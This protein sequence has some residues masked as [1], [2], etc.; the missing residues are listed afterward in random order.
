MTIDEQLTSPVF[1]AEADYYALF[2][3]LRRE[4]PVRWTV[5]PNRHGFWSVFRHADVSR[6]L[7]DP[8]GF[9]SEREGVMPLMD[10]Q[11]DEIAKEAFGVGRNVATVDPPRHT[12]LRKIISTP[13]VPKALRDTEARTA[14]LVAE[15]FDRI[16]E[17]GEC[18]LVA[19]IG[20]KIPMA[21][22][23]DVLDLP[24]EDWDTM[25]RWGRMAI[26]GTDPEFQTG[27]L[28]RGGHDP[29]WL[30]EHP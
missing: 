29:R 17:S 23:C 14:R 28:E 15:I 19:D 4:K 24:A 7:D 22:I 21:V 8:S 25:V 2:K 3:T 18:D 6:V 20:A 11:I 26:G 10:P 30:P 27:G 1:F 5:G 16:P 9:S 12:W 13:F